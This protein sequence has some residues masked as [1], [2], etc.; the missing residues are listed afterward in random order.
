MA[1]VFVACTACLQQPADCGALLRPLLLQACLQALQQR[2]ASAAD[3][4]A[5]RS[6]FPFTSPPLA[7]GGADSVPESSCAEGA[8]L[9]PAHGGTCI[10][11]SNAVIEVRCGARAVALTAAQC[12]P[13]LLH[14]RCAPCPCLTCG[15]SALGK[16]A[17]AASHTRVQ[18]SRGACP[19]QQHRVDRGAA[20]G[21]VVS[22]C[23]CRHWPCTGRCLPL[24]AQLCEQPGWACS[25]WASDQPHWQRK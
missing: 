16:P 5:L 8:V 4:A 25:M 21:H 18:C 17:C 6:T 23:C 24:L 10:D 7:A 13:V 15:R 14:N 22:S 19:S 20:P 2:L 3:S 11:C 1:A 12:Q 9:S